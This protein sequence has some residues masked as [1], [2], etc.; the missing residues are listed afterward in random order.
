MTKTVSVIIEWENAKLSE[1][2][3]ARR[4]LSQLGKQMEAAA[5]KRQLSADLIVL[6]DNEA[7]DES[8]PREAVAG[9]IP[10]ER[11]PGS[12]RFEPAPHQR[13]YEQKNTGAKLSNADVL[14][15]LDSD[16]IPDDGWLEGLLS[17]M[18]DPK[19][20]FVGGETYH[21]TDTFYDK[22]FAA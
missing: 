4:M 20:Q 11:W 12:I 9:A 16:V 2:D 8:I 18:E 6:Y 13:Y 22:M 19:V 10:A 3:R 7:I 15:F 14:V 21:A 17:A 5:A 1:L